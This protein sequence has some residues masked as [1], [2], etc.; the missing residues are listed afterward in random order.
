MKKYGLLYKKRDQ[1]TLMHVEAH[2]G[3][4][5]ADVLYSLE[6]YGDSIWLVDTK[7]LAEAARVSSRFKWYECTTHD[8]PSNPFVNDKKYITVVEVELKINH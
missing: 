3:N 8:A 7:E 4:E 1:N 5:E 6:L 2:A